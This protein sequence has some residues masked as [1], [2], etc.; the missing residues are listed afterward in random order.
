MGERCD[1]TPD[2]SDVL[3]TAL[4]GPIVDRDPAVVGL[5]LKLCQ[6]KLL[7][8][9]GGIAAVNGW[10]G[11]PFAFVLTRDGW[12]QVNAARRHAPVRRAG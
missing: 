5:C 2:E 6:R 7:Q 10:R 11:S 4:C 1:L 3:R 12:S 8:R 9:A